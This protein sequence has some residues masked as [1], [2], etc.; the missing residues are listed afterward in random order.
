MPLRAHAQWLGQANECDTRR[1]GCHCSGMSID[2][3][4]VAVLTGSKISDEAIEVNEIKTA[5]S[6]TK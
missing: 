2:L 5:L 4:D 6:D 1:L 3:R